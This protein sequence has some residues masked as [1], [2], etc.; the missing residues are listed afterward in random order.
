MSRGK[1]T[2]KASSPALCHNPL[3]VLLMALQLSVPPGETPAS[4][5]SPWC[6]SL[7]SAWPALGTAAPSSTAALSLCGLGS[8]LF[9]HTPVSPAWNLLTGEARLAGLVL[10]R[11]CAP[12]PGHAAVDSLP[13][14]SGRVSGPAEGSPLPPAGC[15]DLEQDQGAGT[16]GV[17]EGPCHLLQPPPFSGL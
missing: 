7:E 10:P 12:K 2:F 13:V 14:L 11:G 4:S 6:L 16:A 5:G 9:E 15:R 1:D 17:S 8:V 3:C